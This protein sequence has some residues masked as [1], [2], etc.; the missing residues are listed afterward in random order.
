MFPLSRNIKIYEIF[1][2]DGTHLLLSEINLQKN[3]KLPRPDPE[4]KAQTQQIIG[5][6]NHL[7]SF[8]NSKS[9]LYKGNKN[10]STSV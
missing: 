2:R 6:S 4:Y 8:C 3:F 9:V 10:N 1:K 5:Y 7:F